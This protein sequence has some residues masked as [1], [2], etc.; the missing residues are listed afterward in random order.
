MSNVK[1]II[2]SIYC[3]FG[4]LSTFY[5]LV[6][7]DH[8]QKPFDRK[9]HSRFRGNIL[10]LLVFDHESRSLPIHH[11]SYIGLRSENGFYRLVSFL[12]AVET[13]LVE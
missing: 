1:C 9:A 4:V 2:K 6:E 5:Q 12:T 10:S 11:C 8:G 7:F 13:H 3:N